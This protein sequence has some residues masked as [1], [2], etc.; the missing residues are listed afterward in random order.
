[1][2]LNEMHVMQG[3]IH[4]WRITPVKVKSLYIK[5][6]RA[7]LLKHRDLFDQVLFFSRNLSGDFIEL[8][9]GIKGYTVLL[10]YKP[11]LV[12]GGTRGYTSEV[13]WQIIFI[14]APEH[15]FIFPD[16]EI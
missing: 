11:D 7:L 13:Y 14:V 4:S 15:Y 6:V 9:P 1:M 2:W 16:Q 10:T 3:V 12:P 8:T 5:N